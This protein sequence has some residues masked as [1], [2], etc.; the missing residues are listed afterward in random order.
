V[1]PI[2]TILGPNWDAFGGHFQDF[3]STSTLA[4]NAAMAVRRRQRR[5]CP[6]AV[7]RQATDAIKAAMGILGVHLMDEGLKTGLGIGESRQ[8]KA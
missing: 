7:S 2:E 4:P 3:F 8:I 1:R 5:S 6:I